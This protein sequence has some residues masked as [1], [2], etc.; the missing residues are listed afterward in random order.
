MVLS[1]EVQGFLLNEA[2]E[3]FL[4]YVQ[5]WTTSDENSS[6]IPSTIN[7]LEL[8][9]VLVKELNELELKEVEQDEFGYIY[10]SIRP[11]KGLEEA[12]PLGLIAHLDTSPAVNGKDV[13]PVIHK[14]YNGVEIKFAQNPDLK[15]TIEDSPQLNNYIGL[16]IITS[17]GDTLLGADDKA[18]IAEIMAACAAWK[19]FPELKHGP[20]VICFTPDE[21][22]GRGTI[23]INKEKLPKFCYTF[24]GDEMGQLEIE[25]FDAWGVILRFKGL[26]VHP[27][28]AKGLMIN[29]IHIACRFLSELP[30]AES[31][32]HTENRQGFYHLT[33]LQGS[34]EEAVATMIIRDY[35]S[36][37][38][39]KRKEFLKNLINKYEKLYSGL[40]IE[41][42]F[43]HQYQNMLRFL[44]KEENAINLAK[45][46][47]EMAGV[48]VIPHAIR[49]GTDGAHLSVQ[50][51]PT[52]N[53]F[54]GGLLFHSRKEYIPTLALQKVAE[55]I[56][57]LAE[58][59]TI[60]SFL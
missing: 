28:Y 23:K 21:E 41:M 9:K 14:N 11:S 53:I 32:E 49:G 13:K 20:I 38:N 47:I 22:V 55:V 60:P 35:D 51:I 4:K 54:T 59:W 30:E 43:K 15:L 48:E 45:K 25:C 57:Y 33:K 56:I 16:D 2:T 19:R 17:Q 7:Q 10:A 34:A 50:G 40:K 39:E 26:S 29:A 3:R 31:P 8:G 12:K 46:A 18:G 24:D 44:E 52:P 5:I 27:G 42:D 58:L 37:K 36:K 1:K 6:S